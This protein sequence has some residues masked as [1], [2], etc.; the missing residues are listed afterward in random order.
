MIGSGRSKDASAG[1]TTVEPMLVEVNEPMLVKVNENAIAHDDRPNYV[2]RWH[3]VNETVVA[4]LHALAS[5]SGTSLNEYDSLA[6]KTPVYSLAR[7]ITISKDVRLRGSLRDL[8]SAGVGTELC[9]FRNM[10]RDDLLGEWAGTPAGADLN[11]ERCYVTTPT[12]VLACENGLPVPIGLRTNVVPVMHHADETE[13]L[14]RRR[15]IHNRGFNCIVE[16]NANITTSV[17]LFSAHAAIPETT[18]RSLG[19]TAPE[20]LA[21]GALPLPLHPLG[22]SEEAATLRESEEAGRKPIAWVILPERHV[23]YT[24]AQHTIADFPTAPSTLLSVSGIGNDTTRRYLVTDRELLDYCV[25][26]SRRELYGRMRPI[27]PRAIRFDAF[28]AMANAT[29]KNPALH[30][31]AYLNRSSTMYA[32]D[33]NTCAD[34]LRTMVDSPGVLRLQIVVSYYLFPRGLDKRTDVA[35]IVDEKR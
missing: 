10:S 12:R 32:K 29:E 31:M 26:E 34:L 4:Y 1:K 18:I 15:A 20:Q 22:T 19:G 23:L 2:D 24:V 17:D 33:A 7:K 27:N 14:A 11:V 13:E 35:C 21:I 8:I 25:E 16:P 5:A 3:P 6:D 28:N 9:A 30:W